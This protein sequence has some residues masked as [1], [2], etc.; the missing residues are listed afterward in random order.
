MEPGKMNVKSFAFASAAIWGCA[1]L[2]VGAVD[3][4][5]SPGYGGEFLKVVSS[6]YPGYHAGAGGW[7]VVIGA[8]Y[9]L[10]DGAIGGVLFAI[11][12]NFCACRKK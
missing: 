3:R 7:S 6:I 11:L 10:L 9:A 8:L 2:M 12:Y 4:W 1:V 5:V